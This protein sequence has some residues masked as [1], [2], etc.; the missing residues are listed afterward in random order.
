MVTTDFKRTI[1]T[2]VVQ[3]IAVLN[4]RNR[5]VVSRRFG[6][7]SGQKQTL[8][9]IGQIYGITRER[10]R[11]IEETS[12]KAI[13]DSLQ[14]EFSP[15]IQPFVSLAH[16][17]IDESG[18]VMQEQD[19]FRT[20]FGNAKNTAANASLVFLMILDNR[21]KRYQEDED[22]NTFWSVD[23]ARQKVFFNVVASFIKNLE[24]RNT[25]VEESQVVQLCTEA[26]MYFKEPPA[27]IAS[28]IFAISKDIDRNVF[29]QVGLTSWP[30]IRPRG[31]RDKSYLVLKRATQPKHFR[32]ITRLINSYKFSKNVANVQTVHNE[33][34]KDKRFVLVGRGM[35]GLTEWG[36][37]R[38]TIKE[39]I[40]DL[41]KEKGSMHKEKIIAHVMSVR[42]VK[43]N[44]IVLG[45]QD[46][47]LFNHDER[48][49]VSLRKA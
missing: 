33:L 13:R 23:E 27:K 40:V 30:E 9:S 24:K 41:L 49:H 5:E 3:L 8:E 4:A 47:R 10:V 37:A 28:L 25:P 43:Q 14:S 35:Y 2:V 26:S 6:L 15:K 29:N 19:L 39:L 18:G 34:I 32:D 42:F 16:T 11:Q 21:L 48:G 44:T 20:F 1:K 12:L 46:K 31:V 17:I 36:Y 45:L 7:K 38:G 22:F